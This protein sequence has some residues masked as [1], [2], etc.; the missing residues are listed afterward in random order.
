[1]I[2]EDGSTNQLNRHSA[3]IPL[4]EET[5]AKFCYHGMRTIRITLIADQQ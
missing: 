3:T 4:Y 2:H 5:V 1:M